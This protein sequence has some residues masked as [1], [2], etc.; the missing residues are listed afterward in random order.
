MAGKNRWAFP[1]AAAFWIAV[2]Q[3]GAMAVGHSLLLPGPLET[4]S[5]LAA[6]VP[7]P[8]F[9]ARI[10]FSAARILG[11]FFL[12]LGAASLLAAVSCG[13]P[14]FKSLLA[15]L[16]QFIKAAPVAGFVILALLW[17]R[18]KNLALLISFLM[19]L[20]VLYGAI[21][22]GLESADR[23][24]LEMARVY[25][26]PFLK[27]LRH[28]WLPGLLPSLIQGC[29]AALGLCWKSGVAAEVI[30]LPNGS[31]GDALYRAKLTL[32]SAEVFAWMV[33]II[34][35]SALFER[36]LLGLLKTAAH[37]LCGEEEP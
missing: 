35:L 9:W 30:G 15:P 19:V 5:A 18:G 28:I 27:Q 24:L 13:L 8:D 3:L 34:A 21:L 29:S 33:V 11:G 12:G 23:Q 31:I 10:A 37:R 36:L 7:T 1:A 26:L 22:A 32:S 6:L 2:W 25:R 4:L 16:T 14:W 17:V 20:P